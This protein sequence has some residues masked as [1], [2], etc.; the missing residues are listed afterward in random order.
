MT[1]RLQIAQA[2]CE[3]R[4]WYDPRGGSAHRYKNLYEEVKELLPIRDQGWLKV[5]AKPVR[6]AI[7]TWVSK[8]NNIFQQHL[9]AKVSTSM[10][11]LGGFMKDMGAVLVDDE[12]ATRSAEKNGDGDSLTV[13]SEQLL[14]IMDCARKVRNRME[15][16]K[17]MFEPLRLT[18]E[19]L[20]R[21]G[22]A[23]SEDTLKRLE[24]APV[25]WGKTTRA[26]FATKERYSDAI[27]SQGEQLKKDDFML[28]R[29]MKLF[30]VRRVS[31]KYRIAPCGFWGT[32]FAGVCTGVLLF[33]AAASLR[34]TSSHVRSESSRGCLCRT[35]SMRL[36]L[37][38][39]L[40]QQKHNTD[41]WT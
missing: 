12:E 2:V 29:K 10:V 37:P 40:T 16:T 8:W 19:L 3:A 1:F 34:D 4:P 25:L 7:L 13:S 31:M 36:S 11:E 15:S 17:L 28:Q 6:N 21:Y 32:G 5:D 20:K 27:N 33:S 35:T 14:H 22:V 30:L 24:E 39:M 41:C 23:V 9:L 26:M 18:V 38:R